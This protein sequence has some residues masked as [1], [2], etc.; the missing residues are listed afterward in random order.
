LNPP[1]LQSATPRTCHL[2]VGIVMAVILLILSGIGKADAVI[3]PPSG[4]GSDWFID[5]NRFSL[6]AHAALKCVDC[7]GSMQ[8]GH[9][10]HPDEKRPDFLKQSA[11]RAY[12]Y[13]RCATCHAFSYKR[14]LEGGHAKALREEKEP[15]TEK[16]T[17]TGEK[18]P[19][20]S[21]GECHSSHYELSGLSRVAVGKRMLGVCA[22][23]HPAHAASYREN[24]HGRAGID[25]KS[26]K[27]AFCTDCHGAHTVDSLK[28]P[29]TALSACRRC[30]PKAQ[31]EFAGIV[32]HASL[33]SVSA[34]AASQ[35]TGEVIWIQRVRWVALAVLALSLVFFFAHSFLWVLREL[36]EK[37]RKH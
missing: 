25:L 34:V 4:A 12:D 20:P 7:H 17:L 24:I 19:A 28:N 30:H 5:M 14:Y 16:K 3:V 22:R 13:A 2:T 33:G 27:A 36:H 1:I 31:T 37:L 9:Q 26:P 11:T 10:Q 23:C 15:S 32:V 6:S 8:E 29:E 35:K 21:C 18:I